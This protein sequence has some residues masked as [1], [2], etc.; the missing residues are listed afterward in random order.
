M[1]GPET[2]ETGA[3][4][5][6]A[7]GTAAG[8]EEKAVGGTGPTAVITGPGLGDL[9][10]IGN[11]EEVFDLEHRPGPLEDRLVRI[12]NMLE[13]MLDLTHV[14]PTSRSKGLSSSYNDEK[15]QPH[16]GMAA[17]SVATTHS[18]VP[19]NGVHGATSGQAGMIGPNSGY[20]NSASAG[21][22]IAGRPNAELGPTA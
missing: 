17:Q 21:S 19:A 13:R 18:A 8:D 16:G 7:S 6:T 4:P 10:T 14:E 1:L 22:N 15:Y 2:D 11:R 20:N 9:L 12:E 5:R 3:V